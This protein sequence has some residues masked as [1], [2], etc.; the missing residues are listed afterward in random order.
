[1]NEHLVRVPGPI[2]HHHPPVV[3]CFSVFQNGETGTQLHPS[4]SPSPPKRTDRSPR[5]PPEEA[6]SK[7]K[8]VNFEED[9]Q[10]TTPHDSGD[11]HPTRKPAIRKHSP[12]RLV[13]TPSPVQRESVGRI[14]REVTHTVR[15][16]PVVVNAVA[17]ASRWR[18][19]W[20][21]EK[22]CRDAERREFRDKL[23]EIETVNRNMCEQWESRIR[24]L[25]H[26][27]DLERKE[28]QRLSMENQFLQSKFDAKEKMVNHVNKANENLGDE[29]L[30]LEE[31]VCRAN[32]RI[33]Q[34]EAINK[35]NVTI[36][37]ETKS[38][39]TAK[40]LLIAKLNQEIENL[41]NDN[42]DLEERVQ[43]IHFSST[44]DATIIQSSKQEIQVLKDQLSEI[45]EEM[46]CE[47]RRREEMGEYCRELENQI[48]Q[49]NHRIAAERVEG[50]Q[51]IAAAS[52]KEKELGNLAD[53]LTEE[54]NKLAKDNEKLCLDIKSKNALI[55]STMTATAVAR[56][57]TNQER[58]KR[59]VLEKTL[60]ETDNTVNSLKAEIAVLKETM[61]KQTEEFNIR[62]D[63]ERAANKVMIDS[64]NSEVENH[65]KKALIVQSQLNQKVSECDRIEITLKTE[66]R[67]N[68]DLKGEIS[69]LN[70]KIEELC[71]IRNTL[72]ER[73]HRDEST[74]SFM[75]Q[76]IELIKKET[77]L[78]KNE[79]I[80]CQNHLQAEKS[81]NKELE[82]TMAELTT[83]MVQISEQ[84]T[85]ESFK[86][87][88]LSSQNCT[89][90]AD[91]KILREKFER[92]S[93]ELEGLFQELQ[94][95]KDSLSKALNEKI[96]FMHDV[97]RVEQESNLLRTSLGHENT[98]KIFGT[99]DSKVKVE[100]L[101]Q[102][103]HHE[104]K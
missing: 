41:K 55:E 87:K 10:D 73:V 34:L 85:K 46:S 27:R 64:L 42:N 20:E 100:R 52:K 35:T 69:S 43:T 101:S 7:P 39:L 17:D 50:N 11:L 78:L 3:R 32:E 33:N 57:E 72:A 13:R 19:A 21:R 82:A 1:M 90:Q 16:A 86:L 63:E 56:D 75:T 2:V 71:H 58:E 12:E 29:V 83:S 79:Y 8:R 89:L 88:E 24:K 4:G 51:T 60:F 102:L 47:N 76:N 9:Q 36:L 25:E 81:K 96:K 84:Q 38:D 31:S 65:K 93:K 54:R 68:A 103:S 30:S 66:E 48:Q 97:H 62:L 74:T 44:Q 49:L 45:K 92:K 91:N 99:M 28:N 18:D 77:Q 40:L 61:E 59:K 53:R 15:H 95:T 104:N 70:K 22:T 37:E 80:I 14:L 26:E 94:R 67:K 6:N 98:S 23:L 5:R